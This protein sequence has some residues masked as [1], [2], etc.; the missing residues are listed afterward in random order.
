MTCIGL[1]PML[2]RVFS[3][4]KNLHSSMLSQVSACLFIDRALDLI[5]LA[6]AGVQLSMIRIYHSILRHRTS[7]RRNIDE[8]P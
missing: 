8:S 5:G 4:K 7:G 3:A 6:K 1:Q 2:K